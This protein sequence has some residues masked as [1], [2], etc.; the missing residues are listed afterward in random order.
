MVPIVLA[1]LATLAGAH[2]AAAGALRLHDER[3]D[4]LDRDYLFVLTAEY[5]YTAGNFSLVD[6][7]S[8]ENHD[9]NL[10]AL[11]ADAIAR[12]YGG[13]VYVINRYGAD[14]IQVLDPEDGFATVRQFTTGA[15]SNPQDICFVHEER[16]FVTRYDAP[17]LWEVNPLT[18]ENTDAIDLSALADPDG[19]PEM[20][21]MAI[22]GELLYVTLQ[23]LDRD[24]YWLPVP[25]SY[26][27][28]ID[29]ETNTLLD[30]DPGSPGLQGVA[31]M[32]TN[33][34]GSIHVDPLTGDFLIAE[35]GS[36]GVLDGGIERLDPTC[37]QSAG[38]VVT[39]DTLGGDLDLWDSLAGHRG[40]AVVL[41]P[42]W[43]TAVVA[44]DLQTG[45]NLG[46][47]I[48]SSEFAYPHLMVDP[49]RRQLLLADFSYAAP[50]LRAFSTDSLG[51]LT[52]EPVD[53][54]LYPRWLLPLQG[55][56][57]TA[58]EGVAV[59]WTADFMARPQ[60]AVD[61][62]NLLWS[63][64]LQERATLEILD[65]EGRCLAV[66]VHEQ[67]I[68]T[69]FEQRWT[70]RDDRGRRLPAGIYLARLRS[71]GRGFTRPIHLLR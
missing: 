17:E 61:G 48:A 14:N 25:P 36:Y 34:K 16:A 24:N 9:N 11:H 58:P 26:L 41:S 43:T 56:N 62:V 39:E 37:R 35:T 30:A 32:A 53:V 52:P 38:F 44:F 64:T 13:L 54:G 45:H 47:V 10:G 5:D 1:A 50:G 55:P 4:Y 70:G 33:P 15:G 59:A 60:P 68:P 67:V 12:A 18:G 69:G 42:T 49:T 63:G 71:G 51:P 7:D 22:C 29:L 40:F 46:T 57:S 23:R 6:L 27:A 8:F 65:L 3:Q 66:L 19:L 2:A 28:V 20:H 21:A 31:L